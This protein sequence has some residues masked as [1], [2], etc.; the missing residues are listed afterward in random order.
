MTNATQEESSELDVPQDE[1]PTEN[2]SQT[3]QTYPI[4]AIIALSSIGL[5]LL[6][7]AALGWNLRKNS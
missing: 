4:L 2:E 7:K 5:L 3:V 6:L 1:T